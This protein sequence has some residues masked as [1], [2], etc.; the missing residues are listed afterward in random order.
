MRLI[1]PNFKGHRR[2]YV[3]QSL[4]ALGI[5][6]IMSIFIDIFIQTAIIASLGATV[7]ILFTIPHRNVSRG[8]YIFGGYTVGI[9][10]GVLC[11]LLMDTQAVYMESLILA[12]AVG[13]AMFLMVIMNLEHPP[14]AALAMGIAVEGADLRTVAAIY[15]CLLIVF[16][17]KKLLQRWLIDLV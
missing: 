2:S 1:D 16:S 8:R 3:V 6:F 12:L 17:G 7:F 5:I 15:L 10:A 4:M 14:A 13:L 11:S 9:I